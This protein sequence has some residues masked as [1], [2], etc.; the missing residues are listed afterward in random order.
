M[1]SELDDQKRNRLRVE[2]GRLGAHYYIAGRFAFFSAFIPVAGN[3]L[4]HAVEM[5]LKGAL[6]RTLALEK[7]QSIGHDLPSSGRSS[8]S[9]SQKVIFLNLIKSSGNYSD[10]NASAIQTK[11]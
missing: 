1:L 3:L 8:T 4:H 9:L 10:L 5:F 6:I 2:F 7:L 11:L